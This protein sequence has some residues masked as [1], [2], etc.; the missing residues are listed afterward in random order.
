MEK[1][2]PDP[3]HKI[4][5]YE[6]CKKNFIA[7]RLNSEY[8]CKEH[9]VRAANEKAKEERDLINDIQYQIKLNWRVLKKLHEKNKTQ[10]T[11]AELN[12]HGFQ[13]KFHTSTQRKPDMK[14][15]IP[16]YFN[17]ALETISENNFKII[18]L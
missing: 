6:R 18:K 8:C 17:F 16:E 13:H 1:L 15:L 5:K 4:C 11:L 7:A 9:K 2:L 3:Y 10:V 14:H 12:F